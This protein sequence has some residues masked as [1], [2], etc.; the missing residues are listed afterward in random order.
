VHPYPLDVLGAETEGMIGYLI[1]QEL[2]NQLPQCQVAT[3]LTQIEVEPRDPAFVHPSKPI[4]PLYTRVEAEKLA[5]ERSWAIAP[6]GD[7]YR[8]VVPSPEPRRILELPTIR[9]LLEAG[10]LVICAGGGGIPVVI[11]AAG[12]IRGV[13]GVIDK[14]LAAALL[15][16]ELGADAL[17]LLTDV[18]AVYDNWGTPQAKPFRQTTPQKLR[19]HQFAPGSMAP[20]I[21]AACR[22]VEATG[23]MAVC[24]MLWKCLRGNEGRSLIQQFSVR[25]GAESLV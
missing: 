17:L 25:W 22:F 24:R 21:E 13:E 16:Q 7:G 11:P 12:G 14:D 9:L 20:K 5:R 15:A 3:L 1:E 23:G 19:Q 8:R 2:R 4:G 10:I 6:D 18:D